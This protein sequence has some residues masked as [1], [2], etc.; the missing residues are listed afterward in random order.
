MRLQLCAFILISAIWLSCKEE[1]AQEAYKTGMEGKAIPAFAIQL[2]DSISY[3]H[4][5]DIADN[6]KLVLF[7]F[8]PT[9]PYCRAQMRDMV[10][11]I[12]R[13]KDHQL[14]ILTNADLKSIKAF[15]DYF[16]LRGLNNVIVGRDTG[17]IVTKT[18]Q[19][20]GVP[21]TAYFNENK[22]LKAA[23]AGRMSPNSLFQ[24]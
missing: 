3:I 13:F 21:F 19:L 15:A 11:N 6:K 1:K 24:F 16:E 23:Y 20:M 12:E 4:S 8:S 22:V 5:K 10:N 7:Y 9:C 17:N 14:C 2:L 18:Y